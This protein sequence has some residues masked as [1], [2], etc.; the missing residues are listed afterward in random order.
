MRTL[1]LQ[2]YELHMIQNEHFVQIRKIN[3]VT[4]G[5][6]KESDLK[7]KKKKKTAD[8]HRQDGCL[9]DQFHSPNIS[10]SIS[11]TFSSNDLSIQYLILI[12]V[13]S[14]CTSL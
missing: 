8:F 4:G 12:C 3:T 6:V 1:D 13:N 11:E 10:A 2:D 5:R 9:S 14:F 7:K